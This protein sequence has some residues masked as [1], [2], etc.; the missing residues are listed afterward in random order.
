MKENDDNC[1]VEEK[2][3]KKRMLRPRARESKAEA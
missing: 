2:E 1:K 3:A